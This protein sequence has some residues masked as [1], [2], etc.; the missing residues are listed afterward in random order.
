[1][2]RGRK[3]SQTE[4]INVQTATTAPEITAEA[5]VPK[6]RGGRPKKNKDENIPVSAAPAVETVTENTDAPAPKKRGGRPKKN[7][8]ENVSPAPDIETTTENE[9]SSPKKR[10]RKPRTAAE[11]I[12][13]AAPVIEKAVEE[14]PAPKK[15]GGRRKKSEDTVSP[16]DPAPAAIKETA[17]DKPKRGRRGKKTASEAPAET[18]TVTKKRGGRR[19]KKADD[20][21]V[22]NAP[23]AQNVPELSP[24]DKVFNAAAD[25]IGN[26]A[27]TAYFAAE[28][29]LTGN[30]T[31]KFYVKCSADGMEVMP[32]NYND[33]D[34]TV[35]VDSDTLEN[36]IAGNIA[37]REAVISGRLEMIGRAS[38]MTA[39]TGLI[40]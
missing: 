2:P 8:T 27:P 29:T 23:A 1:M 25:K 13:E 40:S 28:V 6:K 32:Y 26:S 12:T 10:G 22:D 3:K 30:V 34:L 20:Q 17:E 15:R 31:G 11:P 33:A 16:A 37:P 4:E 35:E 24:F 7:N 39:F 14:N 19:S 18:E 9:T 5:S 21:L 36:I 38:I